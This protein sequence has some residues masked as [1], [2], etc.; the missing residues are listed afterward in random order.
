[1]SPHDF[2]QLPPA[3]RIG[4]VV[5]LWPVIWGGALLIAALAGDVIRQISGQASAAWRTVA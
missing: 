5:M 3:V 1:M 4:F 2:L